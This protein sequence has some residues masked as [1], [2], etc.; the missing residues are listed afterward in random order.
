MP[1]L[2]CPPSVLTPCLLQEARARRHQVQPLSP[3]KLPLLL[4]H[5]L[6]GIVTAAVFADAA[7][8]VEEIVL[9]KARARQRHDPARPRRLTDPTYRVSALLTHLFAVTTLPASSR[10][11][12]VPNSGCPSHLQYNCNTANPAGASSRASLCARTLVPVP[13]CALPYLSIYLSI[14]LP[15]HI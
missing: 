12:P 5:H 15:C 10:A 11:P 6:A 4:S 14:Y 9:L 3:G 1:A 2:P 13:L 8:I 7:H